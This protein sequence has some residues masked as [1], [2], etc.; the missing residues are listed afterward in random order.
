MYTASMS[1]LPYVTPA[2]TPKTKDVSRIATFYAGIIL[3]MVVAQLFTFESFVLL[4][5]DFGFPFGPQYPVFLSAFL[6]ICEVFALP[7]LLRMP[8]SPAFRWVSIVCGWLVAALWFK[9]TVWVVFSETLFNN[10][11]FIGT[12]VDTMPGWWAIFMSLAF[13]ILAAWS[14][15]GMWPGKRSAQRKK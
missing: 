2:P 15:W 3:V 12:V 7:F 5:R 4:F 8:L 1:I 11:G 10:V 6:V 14:T 9:I 13:G